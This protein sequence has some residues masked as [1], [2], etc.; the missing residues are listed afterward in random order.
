[1]SSSKD[2]QNT[3]TY[4]FNNNKELAKKNRPPVALEIIGPA[5]IGKTSVIIDLQV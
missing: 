4:V 3:L 2:I 1:M 5:G